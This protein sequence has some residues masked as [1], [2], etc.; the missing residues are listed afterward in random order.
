MTESRAPV[1]GRRGMV[2]SGHP[3]ASSTGWSMLDRG[4]AVVDAAVAAAAVL[5]VV[6]PQAC[7]LGGDAFFLIHD[8][9]GRI[10]RGLNASGPAPEGAP[11]RGPAAPVP[12]RDET[13][14]SSEILLVDEVTLTDETPLFRDEPLVGELRFTDETSLPGEEPI[15]DDVE[16]AEPTPR[17][18]EESLAADLRS[19]GELAHLDEVRFVGDV[20]FVDPVIEGLSF[21][22]VDLE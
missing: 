5:T 16:S 8:G 9:A 20:T 7:T 19:V 13:L 3:L 2:V 12:V 1:F 18:G 15:V 21:P 11:A 6:L 14:V 17:S 4:G 10:T 22:D